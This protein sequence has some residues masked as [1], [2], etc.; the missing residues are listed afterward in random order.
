VGFNTCCSRMKTVIALIPFAFTMKR[1][2]KYHL[3]MVNIIRLFSIIIFLGFGIFSFE[4]PHKTLNMS[5]FYLACLMIK[6]TKTCIIH[7]FLFFAVGNY[8]N[9]VT[10]LLWASSMLS[11]Q[12]CYCCCSFLLVFLS[13]I[14]CQIC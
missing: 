6:M 9:L 13:L 12:S 7:V 3:L 4:V 2:S 1:Q 5:I 8:I 10:W 11:E 14:F